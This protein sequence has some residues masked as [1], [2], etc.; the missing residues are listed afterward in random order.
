MRFSLGKGGNFWLIFRMSYLTLVI[1]FYYNYI[2]SSSRA[3]STNSL[4]SL[5]T[6]YSYHASLLVGP[7]VGIQC[8]HRSWT[9][10]YWSANSGEFMCGSS[11]KNFG[12]EFVLTSP[13]MSYSSS[14][15]GLR[16]GRQVAL[17]LLFCW[18]LLSGFVQNSILHSYFVPI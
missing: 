4:D 10:L 5:F 6:I 3:Y 16:D 11:L 8:Q 18:M 1:V 7:L 12:N 17:Q 15:D 9:C 14:L 2:S 13:E